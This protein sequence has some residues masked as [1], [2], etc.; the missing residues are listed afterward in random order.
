MRK[1]ARLTETRGIFWR[2]PFG[3]HL[4]ANTVG[5]RFFLNI[6]AKTFFKR[7]RPPRKGFFLAYIPMQLCP[8]PDSCA[9]FH[10][11][12]AADSLK[13]FLPPRTLFVRFDPPLDF[14]ATA[15]CAAWKNSLIQ[16]R[17][18][19]CFAADNT[20]PPD[21]VILDLLLSE[22]ELLSR[23]KSKWRYNIGLAKKK[24]VAA[25][26]ST[27]GTLARDLEIFYALY[28]ETAKRDKIA[29]HSRAF[30]RGNRL[31][32]VACLPTGGGFYGGSAPL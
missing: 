12:S 21:T 25:R 14:D 7:T 26:R 3:H 32:F 2:P 5:T 10:F 27:P 16:Q 9:A 11:R 28:L 18:G 13:A 8:A 24:G 15:S 23:M 17:R 1:R 31:F 22:N 30:R 6:C 4:K 29:I 20:Q 19:I